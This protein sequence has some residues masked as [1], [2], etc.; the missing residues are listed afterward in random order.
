M[1]YRRVY[2]FEI[3][4]G[5]D[6]LSST[7]AKPSM[8]CGEH[9]WIECWPCLIQLFP[10]FPANYEVIHEDCRKMLKIKDSRD[11]GI[12]PPPGEV[13]FC[14]LGPGRMG[15]GGDTCWRGLGVIP[16]RVLLKVNVPNEQKQPAL[17][18]VDC[19]SPGL[20][21]MCIS[22]YKQPSCAGLWWPSG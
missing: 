7:A 8:F 12:L 2:A 22:M 15:L 10:S 11:A 20:V 16:F 1:L 13:R 18:R 21:W 9:N 14:S 5:A 6:K 19:K 3:L 17:V 4:V